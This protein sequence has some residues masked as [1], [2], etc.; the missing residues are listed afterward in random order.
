MEQNAAGA[1]QRKMS[2]VVYVVFV[3]RYPTSVAAIVEVSIVLEGGAFR[4]CCTEILCDVLRNLARR[5]L[6]EL[7]DRTVNCAPISPAQ[8]LKWTNPG[9]SVSMAVALTAS[10][11][12]EIEG[13]SCHQCIS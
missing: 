12:C 7:G 10:R 4:T 5:A 2:H 13:L 6:W 1:G 3:I 8:F 9:K 11:R